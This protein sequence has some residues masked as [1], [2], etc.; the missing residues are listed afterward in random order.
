VNRVTR[1]RLPA[2]VAG[3]LRQRVLQ[4]VGVAL[5]VS[6]ACF[7]VVQTLPG[8]IAFRIAAGRYGYDQVDAAAAA[9]VRAELGLDRPLW[10]QLLS[11]LADLLRLDLGTSVVTGG[12]V[13]PELVHSLSG[14]LQ[15]TAVALLLAV[16][17]GATVGV[18]AAS[19]PGGVLDRLSTVWVSGARAV[20]PFLLG[21][22]LILV[23]S[24]YL[25]L[26]P[27]VGSGGRTGV[28][29]PALTLAVGLSGIF[30]RVTRDA[31][32][33]VRHSDHVRFAET[34][35]LTSRTVLAR[36]VVRNAGVTLVA[37]VGAQALF[38]IEGVVVVESLFG[39]DGL[40]HALVHAVFWR[41]VPVL[42]A[43]VLALGLLVVAI[44]TAV[45]LATLA[46]DPRPRSSGVVA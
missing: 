1:V 19:R 10:Q 17:I 42:Q 31:V 20:P 13:R 44:N 22:V 6:T 29:L 38:L 27:A 43:S 14:T 12:S 39:W 37:Y 23:F 16:G 40:G 35:G 5:V 32:V 46:I 24:V 28:L 30:A 7:A 3:V 4:A 21:L 36:H 8:D 45:D 9:A 18:L 2:P 15:L 33:Q 11:W 25:D 41:D 26:L 34:K